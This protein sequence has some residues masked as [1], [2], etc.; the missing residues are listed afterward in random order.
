MNEFFFSLFLLFLFKQTLLS[1]PCSKLN[2][3]PYES[4][5]VYIQRN[6]NKCIY[7]SFSNP[8]KGN[9][10]LKLVKSNSYTSIIYIYKNEDDI[11]YNSKT[12]QF[13]NFMESYQIG[14]DFFKEKKL[15]NMDMETYYFVIFENDFYFKDEL[16]IYNDKF[17]E[18]NYYEI[19]KVEMNQRNEINFKYEYANNNPIIIHFKTPSKDVN[20]LNYQF[21]NINLNGKVSFFIYKKNLESG[22]TV[23]AV[24]SKKENNNYI[25][26]ESDTDYYIK[27]IT[28]GEINLIFDFLD[29]KVMKITP[30]DIFEKELITSNY[31]YFYIEKELIFENDEYFNEFTIKL[32]STN[33]DN[34]PF[35]IITNT[36]EKNTEKD[37]EKCIDAVDLIPKTIIKRDIDIPYI[38]HIYYSFNGLNNLVIKIINKNSLQ[39][40][41]RIIIEASGGNELVDNKH[42]KVFSDNK[43]YLYPVYLNV[44]IEYINSELNSNKS[45]ILFINTNTTSAIKIFYNDETFKKDSL[46]IKNDEYFTIENFVY[47]FDFN[48]NEVKRLFGNRKYFTVMIYCPW[49]S[50]PISFQLTFINDNI[51]N[52]NYLIDDNR[53]LKTPIKVALSSPNEK[54]YFIGQYNYYSSDIL[55]NEV[56]YGKIVAKYKFFNGMD[57]LSRIIFNETTEGYTY[58]KWTPIYDRIDIIEITCIS[59]TLLYMHFIENNAIKINDIILDKGSQNYIF[60]NNTNTYNLAL[61]N[62][63][64]KSK[65]VKIEVMIVSERENQSIGININDESFTLTQ[66][67]NENILRYNSGEQTLEQF[68]I[69]G[70]GKPTTFRIKIGVENDK[71]KIAY[72]EEYKK[73]EEKNKIS[74]KINIDINNKNNQNVKLCYTLNF[75]SL[76]YL[77]SPIDE[78]CFVLNK[79]EKTTL[80]MYNPWDKYLINYNKLYTDSD[81]YYISIYAEDDSL[82]DNLEFNSKQEFIEFD[83]QLKQNEL[84]EINKNVRNLIKSSEKVNQTI[85][86]QFYPNSKNSKNN[87]DSEKEDKYRVKSKF[88]EIIQEGKIYNEKNRTFIVFTDQLIDTFLELDIQNNN[89][90]EVKYNIISNT[91]N[92]NEENIND[93]YT[94][95]LFTDKSFYI[96]FR[97]LIKGK[98]IN[99]TLY[100]SFDTNIDLS[101]ISNLQTLKNDG[102]AIYLFNKNINTKDDFIKF[103]LNSDISKQIKNKNYK[104]NI[105]A[106]EIDVYNIIMSYDMIKGGEG[107]NSEKNEKKKGM[108]TAGKVFLWLFIIILIGGGAYAS[109]FFLY[110]KKPKKD[111]ELL[112]EIKDV[113]LSMED[114][115]Q[116]G[117]NTEEGVV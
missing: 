102:K 38:Y 80:P 99:Y 15:E 61:S 114:Q 25:L 65:N 1:N 108:S 55:F 106:E 12:E 78:N 103:D 50:S 104:I 48:K 116:R 41:Q 42:D 51:Y 52:F 35:D 113:N 76:D 66:V 8:S 29:T 54:Y 115:S 74:Q 86:I 92:F 14:K 27:I 73:I 4:N 72:Y 83:L 20:Y 33:L 21:V 88:D 89:E 77:H 87:L 58:T 93:D 59:P 56:V 98:N 7:F 17:E 81:S 24:E 32:D 37:L 85:L 57:K 67:K 62:D 16:I 34:L 19:S 23:E 11:T 5:E 111:D 107:R 91:N 9:I 40:K 105:L 6:T 13:E 30:D 69:I 3:K 101:K 31:F 90:Y 39:N 84:T 97:P 68:K 71:K 47:G 117:I 49:E 28:D 82:I 44:S 18:N 2:I 64:K 112:K 95:K 110:K 22:E 60:L 96:Q 26:M 109:Y 36:C 94:L 46:E 45:R 100:L 79:N 75:V 70:M 53:P 43:G 63:L 10:I